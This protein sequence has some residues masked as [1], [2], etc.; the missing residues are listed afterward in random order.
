MTAWE[1][2]KVVDLI[3]AGRFPVLTPRFTL[4]ALVQA[5]DECAEEAH[6]LGWLHDDALSNVLAR[7]P[8]RVIPA[9]K[10]TSGE[11]GEPS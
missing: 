9:G 6:A 10:T 8:Y 7:N 5:W 3:R 1:D 4:R 2:R 11:G